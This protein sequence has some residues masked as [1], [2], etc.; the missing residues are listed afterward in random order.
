MVQNNPKEEWCRLQAMSQK[1]D[2]VFT[3][4]KTRDHRNTITGQ[5]FT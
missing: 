5:H 2:N 3:Y 1:L 4:G